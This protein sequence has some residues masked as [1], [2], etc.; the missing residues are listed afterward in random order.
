MERVRQAEVKRQ[1][2]IVSKAALVNNIKVKNF[3]N[4]I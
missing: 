2:E 1:I 4:L 3:L